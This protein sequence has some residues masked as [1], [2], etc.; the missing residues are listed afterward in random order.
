MHPILIDLGFFSLPTYGVLLAAGVLL[1]L[2]TIKRRADGAGLDGSRIVDFALRLVIWALLGAKIL[3]VII[4]WRR[5]L[6]DPSQLFGLIRAGGVFLG[7][8]IAAV[9]AA[10]I[11]LR[12]YQ[13]TVLST[14]DV[15]V[16]S[17]A[18]GQ[19]IGRVGCLMAGCCW[20]RECDLP[21]AI[22]YTDPVAAANVGSPL[23]VALHPFP[24]YAALFNF[25]V[26]LLLSW[27]YARRPAP[28]RVFASYLVVYGI[29]RFLLEFSRGDE[30]RGLYLNS[31]VSTSQLITGALVVIGASMH[32]WISRRGKR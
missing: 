16:P 31:T 8:F 9:I 27:L 21:W 19:A 29:G 25:S 2:W 24:A 15:I 18:L 22:T 4:E 20:G 23:H 10:I 1:A 11:M 12:R 6:G 28:G 14:F 5:Y 32:V 7:G 3:L 30:V 17:L 26:F 13:L